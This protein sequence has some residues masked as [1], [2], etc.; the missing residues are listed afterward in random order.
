[1]WASHLSLGLKIIRSTARILATCHTRNIL[2]CL[3]L[4]LNDLKKDIKEITNA[5][6]TKRKA[7][8]TIINHTNLSIHNKIIAADNIMADKYCT[9]I[10]VWV[11][12]DCFIISG[13]ITGSFWFVA[14]AFQECVWKESTQ[15]CRL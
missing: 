11:D 5:G 15:V 4:N 14:I 9:I 2:L 3:V 1:M 8:A 7:N 6:M 10:Q 12:G 13:F